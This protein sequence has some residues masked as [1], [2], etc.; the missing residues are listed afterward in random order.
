MPSSSASI[1]STL[2]KLDDDIH[3]TIYCLVLNLNDLSNV[4]C[5]PKKGA[6]N[7]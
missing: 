3:G 6:D 5:E 7:D 2:N 1:A 4:L